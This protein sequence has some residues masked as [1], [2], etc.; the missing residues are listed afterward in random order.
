MILLKLKV[1]GLIITSNF[2]FKKL[3]ISLNNCEKKYIFNTKIK[4][5]F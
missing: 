3:N 4:K 5:W 1:F 2:N